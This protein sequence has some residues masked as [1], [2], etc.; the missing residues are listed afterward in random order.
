MARD[1]RSVHLH[2]SDWLSDSRN[3]EI[4]VALP[5]KMPRLHRPQLFLL[6]QLEL[7]GWTLGASVLHESRLMRHM[8]SI[9]LKWLSG[10]AAGGLH[11]R[12]TLSKNSKT[13]RGMCSRICCSSQ[14]APT[15]GLLWHPAGRGCLEDFKSVRASSTWLPYTWEPISC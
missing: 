4:S 11:S 8:H 15:S 5:V 14:A 2:F 3:V 7:D 1:A 13:N 10:W 6:L 9:G 12:P